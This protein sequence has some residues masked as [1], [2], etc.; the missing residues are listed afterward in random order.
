MNTHNSPMASKKPDRHKPASR[1][2]GRHAAV[3]RTRRPATETPLAHHAIENR[4]HDVRSS[5]V[6][7]NDALVHPIPLGTPLGAHA[8][9]R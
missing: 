9:A 1:A 4:S 5:L 3:S 7:R 8:R 6:R 2:T